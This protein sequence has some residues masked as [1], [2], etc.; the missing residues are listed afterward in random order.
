MF[1]RNWN[2]WICLPIHEVFIDLQC[3]EYGVSAHGHTRWCFIRFDSISLG[4]FVMVVSVSGD[5]LL[6]SLT[7]CLDCYCY[8]W[9]CILLPFLI[10]RNNQTTV[11]FSCLES[12]TNIWWTWL[13]V[14]YFLWQFFFL[15]L[16][17]ICFIF[18][19]F[20]REILNFIQIFLRK[21]LCYFK[22][23]NNYTNSKIL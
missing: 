8:W 6:F 7:Q 1:F 17:T 11:C 22:F 3:W 4:T 13:V 5:C 15:N 21:I 16:F 12:G 20:C 14:G 23:H 10:G 2:T 9:F 19:N 18:L